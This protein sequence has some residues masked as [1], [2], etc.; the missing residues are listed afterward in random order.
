MN[1]RQAELSL[2]SFTIVEPVIEFVFGPSMTILIDATD[3]AKSPLDDRVWAGLV[4]CSPIMAFIDWSHLIEFDL[5]AE[6]AGSELVRI[7]RRTSRMESCKPTEVLHP[8]VTSKLSC[9]AIFPP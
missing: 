3:S 7:S 6:A 4:A 9:G 2:S 5:V 1:S 8:H